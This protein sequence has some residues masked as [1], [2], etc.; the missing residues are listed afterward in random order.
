MTEATRPMP[1]RIHPISE[2]VL[3][4]FGLLSAMTRET[5][6]STRVSGLQQSTPATIR[7]IAAPLPAGG[8]LY[9]IGGGGGPP[10]PPPKPPG[11]GGGPC[12]G[13]GGGGGGPYPPGP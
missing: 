9:P 3:D 5:I 8:S 6:P 7:P 1:K 13:G 11:G 10:I 4:A 12:P 2:Q